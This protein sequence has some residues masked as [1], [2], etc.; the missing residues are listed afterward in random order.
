MRSRRWLGMP[1]PV[2]RMKA[3]DAGWTICGNYKSV[4][5]DITMPQADT[6]VWLDLPRSVVMRRVVGRTLRRALLRQELWN[7][8]REPLTNFYKWD[9]E[10]NIIRWA[11]TKHHDYRQRYL[12]AMADGT[13]AHAEVHRLTS[14]GAV[15]KFLAAA[16]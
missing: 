11:W 1:G 4:S 2:S 14:A 8:N 16:A 10:E 15:S 13:W 9:P 3:C 6:I 7:G 12:E 5:W